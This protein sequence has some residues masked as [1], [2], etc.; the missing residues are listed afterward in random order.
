MMRRLLMALVRFYQVFFSH[1]LNAGCRY[2]PSCSGYAMQALQRHGAAAGSYL[3][4]RRLLRCHP[5]CLGGH[6][7]VPEQPPRLFTR[8]F[9]DPSTRSH[10]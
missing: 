7:P 4:A 5:F 10:P 8:L 3:A 1:W 9:S 2:T 6:D